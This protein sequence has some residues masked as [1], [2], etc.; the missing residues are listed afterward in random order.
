MSLG[1]RLAAAWRA[2]AGA[3]E[4]KMTS[5][6]L[7]R[8][9]HGGRASRAGPAVTWQSAIAVSAVFACARVLANGVAQVPWRV[10]RAE[11]EAR[12]QAEDHALHDVLRRRPN[13]WQ[14]SFEFRRQ[15]MLHLVLCANAFVFVNR[16]RGR[17]VE[18]LPIEPGMV[19]VERGADWQPRYRVT[20]PG[21]A[22]E[23]VPA[24]ALWHIRGPSWNG[25][26]GL[27]AVR[28]A[29]ESIG[30]ALATEGSQADMHR[31]GVRPA[32]LYAVEGLLKN[33]QFDAL[34][35]HIRR[36]QTEDGG[37]VMILDRKATFTPTAMTGVDAQHLETRRFQVEEICRFFGVMPIMVGQADK[38][39][40]YASAEQMF[41]AH[42]IHTL[43]PWYAALEQSADAALLTTPE[44]AAGLYTKFNATALL[45][46]DAAG[47]A[48][49]FAKALGAGGSPAWMTADEVRALEE[50]N[51]M[52]G[53]AARLPRPT[54]V[55]PGS[56]EGAADA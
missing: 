40:T 16:V 4:A 7:W 3:R 10:M 5:E 50:L 47:R 31:A 41:L 20:L 45:R 56:Q 26:M 21:G 38:A 32:G 46:G 39:S 11:G 25:W 9:I 55:A 12:R 54:N 44:R 19:Q 2:L 34:R 23:D 6:Q 48:D 30:L 13:P 14:S 36:T 24:E 42:V 53:D 29:R 35:Q 22:A 17:V 37:G 43:G 8:E 18:L 15:I 49:Y 52:G 51:P 27:D 1:S 33:E 28:L